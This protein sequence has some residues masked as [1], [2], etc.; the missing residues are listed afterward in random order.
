M[1]YVNP[2][3]LLQE[4]VAVAKKKASLTVGDMLIRG[5]LAVAVNSTGA[6]TWRR[7]WV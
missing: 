3:E 5:V 6:Q 1:D 7:Q 4:A 2:K